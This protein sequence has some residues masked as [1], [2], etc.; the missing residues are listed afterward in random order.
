[1]N[2][3][4]E[5]LLVFCSSLHF[6]SAPFYFPPPTQAHLIGSSSSPFLRITSLWTPRSCWLQVPNAPDGG[7]NYTFGTHAPF[8][9]CSSWAFRR[10]ELE[11]GF[12]IN[13]VFSVFRVFDRRSS[14]LYFVYRISIVFVSCLK[15]FRVFY[16]F[17]QLIIILLTWK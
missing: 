5:L 1:M 14:C 4:N 7:A 17:F 2:E 13:F 11:F 15:F 10:S 3:F 8:S 6:S 9:C 16:V 12:F